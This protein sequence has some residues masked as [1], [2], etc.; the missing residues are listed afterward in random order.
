MKSCRHH[1][2]CKGEGEGREPATDLEMDSL[3]AEQRLCPHRRRCQARALVEEPVC[4][5]AGRCRQ[6]GLML[7][8]HHLLFL[9]EAAELETQRTAR[10]A[11]WDRLAAG[12]ARLCHHLHP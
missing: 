5:A 12:E 2:R 7:F 11:G 10:A 6:A 3:E 9:E 4:V 8:L 1:R